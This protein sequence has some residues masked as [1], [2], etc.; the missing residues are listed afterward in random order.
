MF[1]KILNGYVIHDAADDILLSKT[2]SNSFVPPYTVCKIG[3]TFCFQDLNKVK[4]QA[5]K[6][7]T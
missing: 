2:N 1:K 5:H 7:G 4:L 3:F 6:F